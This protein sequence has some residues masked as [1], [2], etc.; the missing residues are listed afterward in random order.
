MALQ[1]DIN[2]PK[3]Q[4]LLALILVPIVV[5]Y[6]FYNFV[7]K[8]E[9]TELNAKQ[10]QVVTYQRR[11]DSMKKVLESPDNLR[12]ERAILEEQYQELNALLP[13]Q[14]NVSLLLDQLN[15]IEQDSKVYMVGFE[16]L[17]TIE[18]SGASYRANQYLLTFESGFHQFSQFLSH[19]MSL[20]RIL[21]FSDVVI[22]PNT[23]VTPEQGEYEGMEDQPRTLTVECT[24]TSYVFTG[25]PDSTKVSQTQ[26]V[27]R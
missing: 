8:S 15:S 4:R 12:R 16:A 20:P 18:P 23:N 3:N 2:D 11:V 22:Q 24:L 7:I 14:E 9:Q 10:A 5:G 17:E 21:S 1:F 6:A 25:F 27:R 26:G 13:D 19:A